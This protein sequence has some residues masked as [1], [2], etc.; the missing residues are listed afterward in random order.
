MSDGEDHEDDD[1]S[2]ILIIVDATEIEILNQSVEV[3]QY[4]KIKM[5]FYLMQNI[6]KFNSI[7]VNQAQY[8]NNSAT[9]RL[10]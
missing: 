6:S 7:L 5:S 3:S 10:I 8:H 1:S 4:F 2:W 9:C